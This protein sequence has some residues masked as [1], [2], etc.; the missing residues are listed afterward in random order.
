M[1]R[2]DEGSR[3]RGGVMSTAFS[4]VLLG[5]GKCEISL[6][7]REEKGERGAFASSAITGSEAGDSLHTRG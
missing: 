4:G 5:R 2:R 3:K 6:R 1:Y 7:T